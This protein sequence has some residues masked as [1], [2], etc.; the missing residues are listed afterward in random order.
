[1]KIK[2]MKKSKKDMKKVKME[3]TCPDC[4]SSDLIYEAGLITGYKYRCKNCNYMGVYVI[5]K[6]VNRK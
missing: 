2:G 5:K 4:G 1:M 3:V 6:K